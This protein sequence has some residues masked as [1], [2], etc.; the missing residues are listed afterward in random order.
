MNFFSSAAAA[1]AF[2]LCALPAFAEILIEDPYLRASTPTSKTG[3]AFMVIKNTGETDDRLVAATAEIAPRIELHTH[4][5]DD[6]GV[7]KMREIEEGIAL[8]A[9]GMHVLRRGGDH[10]MFMGLSAPLVQ[11]TEVPVT[12]IFERAGKIGVMIPVDHKR[13]PDH[14]AMKQGSGG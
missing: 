10:V 11:G 2:A 3:A 6:N 5:A 14:G 12:L 4:S 8:P 13:K 1:A 7:M 9:G